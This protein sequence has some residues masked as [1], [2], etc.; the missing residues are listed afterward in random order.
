MAPNRRQSSIDQA[1]DRM[2]VNHDAQQKAKEISVQKMKKKEAEEN[3]DL[4]KGLEKLAEDE[5]LLQG[6]DQLE[7]KDK[8]EIEVLRRK[9]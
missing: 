7:K 5:K 6:L 4:S 2:K 9:S 8:E 1:R 3:E